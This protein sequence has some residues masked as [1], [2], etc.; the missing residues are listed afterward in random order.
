MYG[1]SM[2]DTVQPGSWTSQVPALIKGQYLWTR[3][4]W[5]YT[6]N[7]NETGYQKTYIPRDG[8]NGRDG[9]AGKDGVGIKSTTIT[10]AGL[11]HRQQIGLRTSLTFNL[12]FSFGR[13]L[14]GR[15]RTTRV[16][17][18]IRFLKLG[19]QVQEVYKGYKV[20][21]DYKVFPELLDVTDVHN[22]LI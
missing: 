11:F 1:I 3:T 22:I 6:D 20:R 15:T 8:N 19:R 9:M 12:A 5:T 21:K 17:L 10:Y 16:R 2:N 18:A 4:I 14:F 13:K 7:T